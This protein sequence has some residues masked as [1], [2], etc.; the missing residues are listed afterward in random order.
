MGIDATHAIGPKNGMMNA[1]FFCDF[2]SGVD[3]LSVLIYT[4]SMMNVPVD[5]SC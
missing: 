2:C 3:K 4:A 1:L 5:Q